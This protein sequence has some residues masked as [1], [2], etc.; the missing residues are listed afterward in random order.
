MIVPDQMQKRDAGIAYDMGN[1]EV[2]YDLLYG[3]DLNEEE[4]IILHKSTI[5]MKMERKINSYQN[6]LKMSGKE[7]EALN[8]LVQGVALYYELQQEADEYHVLGEI[9]DKYQ[10]ILAILSD[11]YG[12]S[13]ADVM[14]IISSE[15]DIVYTQKITAV[16]SGAAMPTDAEQSD[17][18]ADV[19]PEEQEILDGLSENTEDAADMEMETDDTPD[20][21]SDDALNATTDDVSNE[22]A[23]DENVDS[24]GEIN[25]IEPVSVEVHQNN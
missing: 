25:Y 9:G 8:A 21:P 2:V 20:A 7:L 13:E 23:A 15:D 5:I 22:T 19:L 10:Q 12:L 6:Y 24:E 14:D 1:Y 3:K 11:Q 18:I 16:L 17:G 4:E